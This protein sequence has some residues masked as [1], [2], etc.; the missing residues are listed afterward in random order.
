MVAVLVSRL[1]FSAAN[2]VGERAEL[3]KS[4][5]MARQTSASRGNPS[6]PIRTRLG[7]MNTQPGLLFIES[8]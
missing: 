7:K 2:A 3:K 6:R 5:P 8:L 4:F 1:S